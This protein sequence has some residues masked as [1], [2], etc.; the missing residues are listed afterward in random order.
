[1]SELCDSFNLPGEALLCNG[2]DSD[3]NCFALTLAPCLIN[4]ST[5]CSFPTQT[6]RLEDYYEYL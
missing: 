2:V 5:I 3:K 1:M 4:K 6:Y